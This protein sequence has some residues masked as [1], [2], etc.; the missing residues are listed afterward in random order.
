MGYYYYVDKH[1][2]SPFNMLSL[3]IISKLTKLLILAKVLFA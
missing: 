2:L 3:A 1:G